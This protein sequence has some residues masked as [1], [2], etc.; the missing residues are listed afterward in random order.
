M[1]LSRTLYAIVLGLF[2]IIF[3]LFEFGVLPTK[4]IPPSNE[5]TYAVDLVS[6]ITA[7]GGTFLLLYA[8]RLKP[9]RSRYEAL[10]GAAAEAF[11][12]KVCNARLVVWLVLM[13]INTVL[14][15]ETSNVTNPKYGIIVLVIAGIFCWP[16]LPPNGEDDNTDAKGNKSPKDGK[17]E[18]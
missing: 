10:E 8:F 5:T 11:A 14:Y 7:F 13:L 17:E 2:S 18:A 4:L 6:I 15:H 16:T 9:I 1:K 12:V 3:A